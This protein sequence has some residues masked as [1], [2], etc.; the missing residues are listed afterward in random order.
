MEYSKNTETRVSK[1]NIG[2]EEIRSVRSLSV[3]V[4]LGPGVDG[5]PFTFCTT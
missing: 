1:Q 4:S 3:T 5:N 2:K